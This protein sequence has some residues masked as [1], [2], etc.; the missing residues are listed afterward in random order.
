VRRLFWILVGA[1]VAVALVLRG[2]K[3]LYQ[4]TPKGVAERVEASG[5]QA[6]N[7]FSEFRATFTAAMREKE[8]EL[9]EELDTPG[10]P[11]KTPTQKNPRQ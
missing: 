1:A 3:W 8:A 10:E 6:V 4:L 5:Q 9:R 7:K 2:R 11:R